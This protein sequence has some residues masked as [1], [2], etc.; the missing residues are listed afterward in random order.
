M[1][2]RRT[3]SRCD[4]ICGS[5]C[6][7]RAPRAARR[8]SCLPGRHN[9]PSRAPDRSAIAGDR[10]SARGLACRQ[11]SRPEKRRVGVADRLRRRRAIG[12]VED[13]T[14][15]G[16]ASAAIA[17]APMAR[18]M[19]RTRLRATLD[20]SAMRTSMCRRHDAARRRRRRR[21]THAVRGRDRPEGA[22][23][24]RRGGRSGH[25]CSDAAAADGRFPI[26]SRPR[27]RSRRRRARCGRAR[28]ALAADAAARRRRDRR[29][30]ALH[31]AAAASRRCAFDR[32]DRPGGRAASTRRRRRRASGDAS[33]AAVVDAPTDGGAGAP[34]AARAS[35]NARCTSCR[36]TGDA[37]APL[38]PTRVGKPECA[39]VAEKEPRRCARRSNETL[40]ATARL[41]CAAAAVEPPAAV[42]SARHRPRGALHECPGRAADRPGR[43]TTTAVSIA[44]APSSPRRRGARTSRGSTARGSLRRRARRRSR[45]TT[46]PV[47]DAAAAARGTSGGD[48]DPGGPRPSTGSLRRRG[49]RTM[50]ATARC[51]CSASQREDDLPAA[52]TSARW[53]PRGRRAG[54]SRGAVE[55][56]GAARATEG[57]GPRFVRAQP[58]GQNALEGRGARS[59]GRPGQ[60]TCSDQ[61]L[62]PRRAPPRGLPPPDRRIPAAPSDVEGGGA[63][64]PQ[65][66]RAPRPLSARRRASGARASPG[67]GA[68]RRSSVRIPRGDVLPAPRPV[69][70]ASAGRSQSPGGS[71]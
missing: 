8:R 57:A 1:R 7:R 45:A 12:A 30:A 18:R 28:R 59:S 2:S 66:A 5:A 35:S 24:Q 43:E 51:R 29:R 11:E 48:V 39:N 9:S 55:R 49:R 13:G 58:H 71:R 69:L 33:R 25:G 68:R 50:V 54:A 17:I 52:G 32:A 6:V 23:S 37:L 15:R 46:S 70:P 38:A 44:G 53:P 47:R 42:T 62:G 34:T 27:A 14:S 65:N 36:S 31:R 41:A 22:S 10:R 40:C 16:A 64:P 56:R 60:P 26:P 21:R 20:A 4:S 3:C 19:L 61:R 67:R 63:P